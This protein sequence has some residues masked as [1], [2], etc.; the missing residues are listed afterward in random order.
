MEDSFSRLLFLDLPSLE[1][2]WDRAEIKANEQSAIASL[3]VLVE[4]IETYR[5]TY[6]RLPECA[7][8]PG[9]GS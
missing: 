7:Q 4:A 8:G 3:K 9:P 5:K 1:I 2:E 6:T